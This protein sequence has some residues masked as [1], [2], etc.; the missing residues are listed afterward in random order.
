M[1][2][3]VQGRVSIVQ[4]LVWKGLLKET[5]FSQN[6]DHANTVLKMNLSSF[7]HYIVIRSQHKNT[8]SAMTEGIYTNQKVSLFKKNG[9]KDVLMSH[10]KKRTTRNF[11]EQQDIERSRSKNN[12]IR[13]TKSYFP[14]LH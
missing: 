12:Q 9:L 4:G 1:S 14:P 3:R 6:E 5:L 11:K 2:S 10:Y 13:K 7:L 8:P